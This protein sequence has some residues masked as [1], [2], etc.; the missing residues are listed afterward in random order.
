MKNW[1]HIHYLGFTTNPL[2]PNSLL[3]GFY[4]HNPEETVPSK[5]T[6]EFLLVKVTHL[7]PH[8]PESL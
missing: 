8:L 5:V 2:L 6:S 1:V 3:S 4:S 7:C